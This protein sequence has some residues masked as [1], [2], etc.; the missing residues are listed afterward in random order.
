MGLGLISLCE[1]HPES[2]SLACTTGV[3]ERGRRYRAEGRT[4]QRVSAFA[5]GAIIRDAY[6]LSEW[7]IE[8]PYRSQRA[9]ARLRCVSPGLRPDKPGKEA[10]DFD[11]D[12]RWEPGA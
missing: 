12:P 2:V 9:P 4:F 7:V 10:L 5:G 6:W 8:R 1:E 11:N 3:C